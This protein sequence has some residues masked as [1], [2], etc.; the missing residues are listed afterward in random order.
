MPSLQKDSI[1]NTYGLPPSGSQRVS[2][3]CRFLLLIFVL[4]S[5]VCICFPLSNVHQKSASDDKVS[6]FRKTVLKWHDIA[7][8]ADQPM[9]GC[10]IGDIRELVIRD[11]QK[12]CQFFPFEIISDIFPIHISSTAVQ[13]GLLFCRQVSCPYQLFK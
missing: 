9:A 7:G 13:D 2:L 12:G 1:P 8:T 4:H 6:Y 5:H 11:V 10:N 3:G